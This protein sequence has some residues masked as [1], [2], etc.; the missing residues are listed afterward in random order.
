MRGTRFALAA[1]IIGALFV[2]LTL[3]SS[4][5][6]DA[7]ASAAPGEAADRI[8]LPSA[9]WNGRPIQAPHR[10]ETVRTGVAG[11]RLRGWSAGAVGYG[12][13]FHRRG[14]S[15]RVREVQRRLASLGYHVGPV[16][17]LFGRRTRASVAW[18][19][20]KHGLRVDGRATAATVRHLR[21]RTAGPSSA[22]RRADRGPDDAAPGQVGASRAPAWEAYRQLVGGRV[23]V[24][25]GRGTDVAAP[26]A[27]WLLIGLAAVDL[28]LLLA[29]LRQRRADR[30]VVPAP[31]PTASASQDE[32]SAPV[33]P[34]PE[35]PVPR[36]VA[37][38][39]LR[40]ER[41]PGATRRRSGEGR[42]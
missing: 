40:E 13:G 35:L 41:P 23:V 3:A 28:L 10:H 1:R 16:D 24:P 26:R 18:F 33:V 12:T 17:G 5:S 39:D 19:Q 31:V 27:R 8:L 4:T 20:V 15:D 30:G 34:R 22:T 37:P 29:L 14:G 11:E 7:S 36:F 9:G 32:P 38:L 42:R 2:A 21:A 6:R 25:G